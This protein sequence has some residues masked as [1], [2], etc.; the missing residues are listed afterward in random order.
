[1]E[2]L[3]AGLVRSGG[4]DALLGGAVQ[5]L[6][7]PLREIYTVLVRAGVLVIIDE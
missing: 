5:V 6:T 3:L 7:P 4:Q 1:M 2:N